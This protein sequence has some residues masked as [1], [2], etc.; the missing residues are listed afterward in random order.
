MKTLF[1]LQNKNNV[2]F[3]FE[4][5]L[6]EKHE[7]FFFF[8]FIRYCCCCYFVIFFVLPF[9]LSIITKSCKI[10][11]KEKALSLNEQREKFG[12]IKKLLSLLCPVLVWKFFFVVVIFKNN[13][14]YFNVLF[15]FVQKNHDENMLWTIV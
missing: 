5:K 15:F 4:T 12:E 13:L 14:M 2:I 10:Y 7:A 8:N 6:L 1:L 9:L 11:D 3:Q